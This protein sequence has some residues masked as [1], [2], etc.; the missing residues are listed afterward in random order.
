MQPEPVSLPELEAL[1]QLHAAIMRIIYT[2]ERSAPGKGGLLFYRTV[3]YDSLSSSSLQGRVGCSARPFINSGARVSSQL[4]PLPCRTPTVDGRPPRRQRGVFAS[5]SPRPTPPG[6]CSATYLSSD[7][8]KPKLWQGQDLAGP[9]TV[10]KYRTQVEGASLR[11]EL[12]EQAAVVRRRRSSST[13]VGH[14]FAA[15]GA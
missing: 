13:L 14:S 1:P 11:R 10:L 5:S 9:R 6:Q 2:W 8:P 3:G 12:G 15:A 7:D 4:P